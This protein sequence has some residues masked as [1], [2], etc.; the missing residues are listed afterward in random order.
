MPTKDP[1]LPKDRIDECA[2]AAIAALQV[3]PPAKPDIDL[4]LKN[5]KAITI[6]NHHQ[7]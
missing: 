2:D 1:R 5:L 3:T 4:A 7:V 6:D